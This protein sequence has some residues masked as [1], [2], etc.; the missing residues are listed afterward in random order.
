MTPFQQ[1]HFQIA[2]NHST[3][4]VI[5]LAY[6]APKYTAVKNRFIHTTK[7]HGHCKVTKKHSWVNHFQNDSGFSNMKAV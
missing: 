6:A 3:H 5:E 2:S 1:L 7:P 4:E